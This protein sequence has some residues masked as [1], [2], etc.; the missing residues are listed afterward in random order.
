MPVAVALSGG[1]DSLALL[2]L[3]ADWARRAGRPVVALTVDHGLNPESRD[4]SR[5]CADQAR[6]LGCGWRD[7]IWTGEKPTTGLPAAARA[8]RHALLAEAARAAGASVLLMGHTADDA[9]ESD[10]IRSEGTPIGRLRDWSPSPAWPE[11]RGLMLLRPLLAERRADL[12][13][14]LR[15]RGLT[16]IEDPANADVRFARA[17]VRTLLPLPAGESFSV[18]ERSERERERVRGCGRKGA[19]R[20]L[21]PGEGVARMDRA[22]SAIE[23]AATLTCVGGGGRPP[24]GDR[25]AALAARM[26]SGED[27]H[28]VLCGARVSAKG[29]DVVVHRETGEQ[30]RSG[31]APLRLEAG[32]SAV[33]DGRFEITAAETGLTVVPAQGLLARLSAGDRAALRPLPAAARGAEPVLIRDGGPRPVLAR[34]AAR[35]RSLVEPRLAAALDAVSHEADLIRPRMAPARPTAYFETDEAAASATA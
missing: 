7:L 8:A 25:L 33:W 2:A 26:S 16:W 5:R 32:R 13:D 20:A 17:R 4:W 23:L 35:T 14:L 22:V 9:A 31:L 3:T 21:P 24:R 34:T 27:F 18:Q 6:S 1:G 11:G 12:R 28:A 15:T 10:V 19:P 29:A 30:R